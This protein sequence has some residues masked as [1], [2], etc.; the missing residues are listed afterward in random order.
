MLH[1]RGGDAVFR[2][3]R[4]RAHDGRPFMVEDST[5]PQARFPGLAQEIEIPSSMVVLAHRFGV[6]LARAEERIS[7]A[8]ADAVCADALKVAEGTPLLKLDAV[9][10]AID[11]RPIEWRIARCDLGDM[12]YMTEIH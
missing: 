9:V 12:Y 5:V 7:V 6:L 1:L 4:V 8:A 3:H 10:Y 11:G 2:L